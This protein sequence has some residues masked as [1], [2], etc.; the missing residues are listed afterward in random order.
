MVDEVMK[1]IIDKG[2]LRW[3]KKNLEKT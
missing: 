3:L 2:I 1:L